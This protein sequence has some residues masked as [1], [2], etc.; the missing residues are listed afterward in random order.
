MLQNASQSPRKTQHENA[1]NSLCKHVFDLTL[2]QLHKPTIWKSKDMTKQSSQPNCHLLKGRQHNP[3][4]YHKAILHNNKANTLTFTSVVLPMFIFP[5][6]QTW[7]RPHLIITKMPPIQT[8]RNL[9]E[10]KRKKR[11][12][13]MDVKFTS[14]EHLQTKLTIIED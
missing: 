13:L 14:T 11:K 10:K 4:T 5:F 9:K 2:A 6:L 12:E 1:T 8:V 7:M 3:T